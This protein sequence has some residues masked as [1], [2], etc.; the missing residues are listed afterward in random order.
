MMRKGNNYYTCW[1]GYKYKYCSPKPSITHKGDSCG[2]NPCKKKLYRG[3]YYYTRCMVD[4]K[5]TYGY[6]SRTD[7]WTKGLGS[8]KGCSNSRHCGSPEELMLNSIIALL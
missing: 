2:N 6:C 7:D 4:G 1:N 3:K 8:G 5:K